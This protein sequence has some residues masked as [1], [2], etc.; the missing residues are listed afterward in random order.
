MNRW[1]HPYQLC[2]SLFQP[3]AVFSCFY[4]ET[5]MNTGC[6]YQTCYSLWY[7]VKAFYMYFQPVRLYFCLYFLGWYFCRLSSTELIIHHWIIASQYYYRNI[8]IMIIYWS[9]SVIT[10]LL[11]SN[12]RQLEIN[13]YPCIFIRKRGSTDHHQEACRTFYCYVADNDW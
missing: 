4:S 5:C 10:F 13:H 2:P 1:P 11:S 7:S 8:F 6:A 9:N 12:L 3:V